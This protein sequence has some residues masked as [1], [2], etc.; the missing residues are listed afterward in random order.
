MFNMMHFGDGST[1]HRLSR[2]LV[3]LCLQSAEGI[4][5]LV[6][7]DCSSTKACFTHK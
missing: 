1:F 7:T 3:L 6:F 2:E 4:C 5:R